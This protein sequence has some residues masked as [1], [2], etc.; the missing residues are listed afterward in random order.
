M[1]THTN[2]CARTHA[3][4]RKHHACP[5]ACTFACTPTNAC[6]RPHVFAHA[7]AHNTHPQAHDQPHAESTTL[8]RTH[9]HIQR[10]GRDAQT[11]CTM[12]P[13]NCIAPSATV[14]V[15]LRPWA[16]SAQHPP[17]LAAQ[18]LGHPQAINIDKGKPP[19]RTEGQETRRLHRKAQ[20]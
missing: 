7:H 4:T 6:T 9:T 1:R 15:S 14:N 16:S 8:A 18:P 19:S 2:T 12:H 3:R 11:I 13:H 17:H 20:E 5:H 10:R